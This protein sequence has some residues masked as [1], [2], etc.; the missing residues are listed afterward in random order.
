MWSDYKNDKKDLNAIV[1]KN[2]TPVEQ[3]FSIDLNIFYKSYK[4]KN[5]LIKIKSY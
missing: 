2:V 4:L 1:K 3:K 5:I